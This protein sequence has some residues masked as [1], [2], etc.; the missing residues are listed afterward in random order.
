MDEECQY[1]QRN[2]FFFEGPNDHARIIFAQFPLSAPKR[3]YLEICNEDF[4]LLGKP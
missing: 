4:T 1:S 3:P 2:K